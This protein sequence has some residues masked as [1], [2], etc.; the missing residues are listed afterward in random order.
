[1]VNFTDAN[2]MEFNNEIPA[3]PGISAQG[4]NNVRRAGI[5]DDLIYFI[6]NTNPD[7]P[8]LSEGTRRGNGFVIVPLADDVEDMQIAYGVD[9]NDD[10]S[11]TRISATSASDLDSNESNQKDGDEWV[12]NASAETVLT[13]V[14]F[15]SDQTPATAGEPFSHSTFPLP[16]T[17]C[18]R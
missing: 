18:P 5:M 8:V 2:A 17:H 15:Q 6:D 14:Q 3:N 10:G 9:N 1:A 13:A 16:K 7:H 11:V 12:P 4:Y